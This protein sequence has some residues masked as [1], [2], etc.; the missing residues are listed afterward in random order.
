VSDRPNEQTSGDDA[1]GGVDCDY[2]R[3]LAEG[4]VLDA[5]EPLER[6]RIEAHLAH[7]AECRLL[8]AELRGTVAF[9]S[10]IGAGDGAADSVA[11]RPSANAKAIVMARIT[12]R[13]P[14]STAPNQVFRAAAPAS[15]PYAEIVERADRFNPAFAVVPMA[16]AVMLALV[17]SFSLQNQLN[18]TEDQL[19]DNQQANLATL[20]TAP[21]G[22]SQM[23]SF[24]PMC[25]DCGHGKLQADADG[26]M[27]RIYAGDL[28]PNMEHGVWLI[29]DNHKEKIGDLD[30]T[31]SGECIKYFQLERPLS[32]YQALVISGVPSD[33]Q[34]TDA[35]PELMIQP[36]A[37]LP[38]GSFMMSA[39]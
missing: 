35:T 38:P 33:S 3:D 6:A 1:R 21:A 29:G 5:V 39:S 16:A 32:S 4:Y 9:M 37:A 31:E 11:A 19:A 2:V 25:T 23:Y 28:D 14:A 10:F 26:S 8:V 24:Q 36:I 15:M 7:C 34:S 20:L 12:G 13:A 18:Q 17:W 22:Q 30:L 27:V